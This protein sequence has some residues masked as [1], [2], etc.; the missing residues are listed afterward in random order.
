[1][2]NLVQTIEK[3]Y[4][5]FSKGQRRIADF[6]INRYDEAAFMTAVRLGEAVGVSESTV[7]RFAYILGLPGYPALQKSLQDMIRNR[8]TSVQRVRL[9]ENL[10]HEDVPR[11]VLLSDI[12]NIKATIDM[13][14]PVCFSGAID[15]L[16]A[17]ARIYV[18]GVRSAA[19][20]AQ[21]LTSYLGYVCDDVVYVGGNEQD[22][23]ERMLRISEKDVFF[24]ISFPR[25]STRTV[26]GMRYARERGAKCIALTDLPASP[27]AQLSD[28][29]LCARSDMASFADSLTAP[30]SLINAILVA[31]GLK[32]K[33]ATYQHLMQLESIWNREGVYFRESDGGEGKL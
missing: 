23:Y 30:L 9:A 5:R 26:Q 16:L 29:A 1:M 21:F 32:R 12:N 8:L 10:R 15:A 3:G 14:D 22:V 13:V 20:L 27:V 33:D 6:L 31:V 2:E 11:Q 24:G 17:A 4:S 28:F 19:P 7:V 18:M 25:Y